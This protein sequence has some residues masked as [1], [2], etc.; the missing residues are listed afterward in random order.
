MQNTNEKKRRKR[1]FKKGDI[2]KS[3]LPAPS[4]RKAGKLSKIDNILATEYVVVDIDDGKSKEKV[5][6][7][8]IEGGA[9]IDGVYIHNYMLYMEKNDGTYLQK[10]D[11]SSARDRSTKQRTSNEEIE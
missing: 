6:F 4:A 5:P 1:K 10:S 3:Q 8:S 2:I 9:Y 7:E 11:N